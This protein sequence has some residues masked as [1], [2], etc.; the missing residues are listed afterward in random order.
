MNPLSRNWQARPC[1]QLA[2]TVLLALV[3]CKRVAPTSAMSDSSASGSG[4]AMASTLLPAPPELHDPEHPPIDCPLRKAGIEP[5]K[6]KPFDDAEKYIAFLERADRAAWQ[7]PDALVASL[8]LADTET[9]VDVGAGSGYFAFRFAKALPRGRVFA[10]DIE[11]EMI[12]HIHHKA[13]TE[14]V[15]NVSAVPSD[16]HDP[17]IPPGAGLIFVCDVLHHV[18]D[19]SGWLS[20]MFAEAQPAA[21]LVIVEFKEGD[22]PQGPPAA[23]KWKRDDVVRVVTAAGFAKTHEDTELLPYQYVLT[24]RRP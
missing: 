11:P 1:P 8:V 19:P 24:F 20:R 4:A 15:T 23:V 2:L 9:V 6:M 14:G 13:L 21:R 10:T 22:L 7:K 3:A 17:K 16:P 18:S 12:R 5:S